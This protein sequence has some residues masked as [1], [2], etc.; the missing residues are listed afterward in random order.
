M[1]LNDGEKLEDGDRQHGEPRGSPLGVA[2]SLLDV[3]NTLTCAQRVEL[4]ISA[5]YRKGVARTENGRLMKFDGK[6]ELFLSHDAVM[7]E[8][9]NAVIEFMKGEN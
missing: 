5:A 1:E 3:F 4:E 2:F 9:V 7:S 6:H 8:Y